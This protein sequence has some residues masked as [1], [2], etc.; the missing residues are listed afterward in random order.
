MTLTEAFSHLKTVVC[1]SVLSLMLVIGGATAGFAADVD[2]KGV[3]L[4]PD[5]MQ[6][7]AV[8]DTDSVNDPLEPL[9]RV[10]FEIMEVA[11]NAIFRPVTKLYVNYTPETIQDGVTNFLGN[12]KEPVNAANSLL[13]GDIDEATNAIGRLLINSTVGIGGINDVTAQFGHKRR[14]EDFGQTLAVWGVGEGPYLYL[15]V[16]GPT[17]PRDFVGSYLVDSYFDPLGLWLSNSDRDGITYGLAGLNGIDQYARVQDGLDQVK[18]SSVDYYAAIRS[19]YR[20][21][22]RSQ[23]SNGK[24]IDLPPLPDL[25]IDF[26]DEDDQGPLADDEERSD[27]MSG[28]EELGMAK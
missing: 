16:V 22:R 6:V 1:A 21:K 7:A 10:F 8:H 23:I 18:K 3:A 19:L 15:P 12:L 20:Q 13:Q 26:D 25:S 11:I 28:S 4:T 5:Y 9:N 27:V 2:E 17:N 14:G 24:D